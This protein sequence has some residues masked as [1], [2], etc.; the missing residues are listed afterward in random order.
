MG[1]AGVPKGTAWKKDEEDACIK[2]MIEVREAGNCH[3]ID[4]LWDAVS[5][6]MLSD[7]GISRSSAAVKNHWNRHLRAKS[8]YD[9]RRTPKPNTLRTG[10][11]SSE[12]KTYNE[13]H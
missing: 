12:K 9:E 2:L 3:R 5:R 6:R 10:L 1:R 4:A 11:L 7:C 13:K 8:G